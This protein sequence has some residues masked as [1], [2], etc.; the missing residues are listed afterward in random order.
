M[1]LLLYSAA[2]L[3]LGLVAGCGAPAGAAPVR[4]NQVNLPPSYQFDPAVIQVVAGTSV[5]WSNN[6]HF[7]HSV[8][9]QDS[10]DHVIR[11]GESVSIPFDKTGEYPYV[12]TFHAQDMNGK[13]IVAMS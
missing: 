7:T 3:A 2:L 10:P 5:T 8:K 6:D 13:V 4:T 11:P 12:C 1:R 9:V